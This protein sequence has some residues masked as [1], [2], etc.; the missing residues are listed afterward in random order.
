M[1]AAPAFGFAGVWCNLRGAGGQHGEASDTDEQGGDDK[2]V[3]ESGEHGAAGAETI[4]GAPDRRWLVYMIRCDDD[5]LYT[6]IT[7][8]IGRR[9]REHGGAA[10]GRMPSGAKF[11]G[12]RRPRQLVYI[13]SGHDRSSASR[14]ELAIKRLARAAKLRL[15]REACN[16][17][18][19]WQPERLAGFG[20]D[21]EAMARD[22]AERKQR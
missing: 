12:G 1:T 3:S 22:L 21:S 7:T 16:E 6:G 9:W 10:A 5:S 11:F 17:I 18:A 14:R 2:G 19:G 4:T 8:D 20:Y 13:E 15:L